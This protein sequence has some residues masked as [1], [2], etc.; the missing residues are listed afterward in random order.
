MAGPG[1]DRHDGGG[2]EGLDEDPGIPGRLVDHP[3]DDA[4]IE[5]GDH[6]KAQKRAHRRAEDHDL[7][8][9]H[10]RVVGGQL[11]DAADDHGD[12]GQIHNAVGLQDG[13]GHH[14]D[15]HEDGGNAQD[16]E[17]RSGDGGVH[18]A[19]GQQLDDGAAQREQAEAAGQGNEGGDAHGG[20]GD[21]L[22]AQPVP[23]G[24]ARRDA[25]HDTGGEG[26]HQ[27]KGQVIDAHG[28]LIG[29]VEG[30]GGIQNGVELCQRV[31]RR[32]LLPG[33]QIVLEDRHRLGEDVEKAVGDPGQAALD[34]GKD[35]LEL[36]VDQV[37]VDEGDQGHGTGA[38]G[39][40]D[41]QFEQPGQDRA[42]R[43]RYVGGGLLPLPGP[44]VVE[45]EVDHRQDAA[46]GHAQQGARSGEP[47]AQILRL[48][49]GA[50][51]QQGQAQA[52]QQLAQGLDDLGDAGG[53]HVHVALGV[54][55]E[56]RT[57]A[58][59]QHRR[60]QRQ[61]GIDGLLILQDVG[62][63]ELAEYRHADKAEYAHE[64]KGAEGH[65][66][67][68]LLL[69]LPAQRVAL[70]Y[71][72]GQGHGQPRRGD[73]QKKAVDIV[74]R[75]EI[76]VGLVGQQGGQR[77]L[78]DGADDLDHDGGHSQQSGRPIKGVLFR[79]A[80][81]VAVPLISFRR[82]GARHSLPLPALLARDQW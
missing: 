82:A 71:G 51:D 17:Q 41:G 6:R 65:P 24:K 18:V 56:G 75:A 9:A 47:V 16:R 4:Q 61:Y 50:E 36:A 27:V 81:Q 39:D 28:L 70:G 55:P 20:F 15:A 73:G 58:G 3:L 77:D 74:C 54:S 21:P 32:S 22:G 37:G 1:R 7:R 31:Q 53:H 33:G 59:A 46:D 66:E 49:G 67:D 57:D 23:P 78:V 48:D 44:P 19:D 34:G 29:A 63:H 80:G 43:L 26:H 10:Q 52:Q 68:P 76:A 35:V 30:A 79:L 42:A 64:Q 38:Q 62:G 25:G 45:K 2:D 60:S 13:G 40:G 8:V 14:L 69:V 72:L 11:D 12:N 5:D